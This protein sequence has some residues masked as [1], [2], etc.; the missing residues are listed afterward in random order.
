MKLILFFF[1]VLIIPLQACDYTKKDAITCIMKFDTNHDDQIN[2]DEIVS[3]CESKMAWYEKMIY[4]PSWIVD[5]FKTDCGLP[6]TMHSVNVASCFES[7]FYRTHIYE[8]LC[9]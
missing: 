9:G 2:S 4:R 5:Q 6:I 3:V 1:L 8:K 7:C